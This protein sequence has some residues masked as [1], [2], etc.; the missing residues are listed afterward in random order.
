MNKYNEDINFEDGILKVRLSGEFPNELLHEGK[1][2][3]QPLINACEK[4]ACNK[5]LIDATDLQVDFDTIAMFQA[6]KDAAELVRFGIH[7]ALLTKAD[8]VNEFFD[9]VVFNR[10]GNLV[11]FTDMNAAYDWLKK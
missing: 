9:D 8:L 2:L 7:I 3:F 11:V 6:G 1:N 4:F 5:V 10:G